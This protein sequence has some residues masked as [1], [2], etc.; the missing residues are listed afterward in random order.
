VTHYKLMITAAH[1]A[2]IYYT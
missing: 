2:A 1:N